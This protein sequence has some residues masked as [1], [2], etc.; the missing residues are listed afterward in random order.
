MENLSII[1]QEVLD[2][3]SYMPGALISEISEATELDSAIVESAVLLLENQQAVTELFDR[4]Y[5]K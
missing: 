2:A 5:A 1:E 3:V 4:Y